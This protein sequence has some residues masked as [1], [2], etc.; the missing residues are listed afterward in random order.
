M[1]RSTYRR[2]DAKPA[3]VAAFITCLVFGAIVL[4]AVATMF[5]I[6]AAS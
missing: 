4:A 2:H 5:M 3:E 1:K 6:G